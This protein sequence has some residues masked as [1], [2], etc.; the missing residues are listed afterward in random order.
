MKGENGKRKETRHKHVSHLKEKRSK[1]VLKMEFPKFGTCPGQPNSVPTSIQ[2]NKLP[3]KILY[4][5]G[6]CSRIY[7]KVMLTPV[8]TTLGSF[9]HLPLW[10]AHHC[11]TTANAR[12]SKKM[13]D[14]L[15]PPLMQSYKGV[16]I[17]KRD[18]SNRGK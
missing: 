8:S 18:T 3:L 11:P 16:C 1:S 12:L 17:G 2:T 9:W 4:M 5:V 13:Q 10:V 7:F 15:P 14:Y 6:M